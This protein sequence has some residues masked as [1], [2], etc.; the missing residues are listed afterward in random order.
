MLTGKYFFRPFTSST[1]TVIFL[2]RRFRLGPPA[3]HC[4]ILVEVVFGRLF[5]R[6]ERRRI[7][8]SRMERA[9]GRQTGEIGRLT[10]NRVQRLLIAK[11]GDRAEQRARVWMLGAIE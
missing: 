11:S 2:P 7:R 9:A 5:C 6:A 8:A 3:T 10:R 1:G 4:P